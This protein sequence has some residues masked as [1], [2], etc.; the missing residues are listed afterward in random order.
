MATVSSPSSVVVDF[1]ANMTNTVSSLLPETIT[2]TW[3]WAGFLA[4]MALTT[5]L[6][7]VGSKLYRDRKLRSLG[8]PPPLVPYRLPLGQSLEWQSR[9]QD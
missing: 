4:A 3:R 2:P 7:D 8:S 6:M 1:A 9:S 5:H